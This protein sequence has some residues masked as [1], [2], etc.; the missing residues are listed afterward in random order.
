MHSDYPRLFHSTK[1]EANEFILFLVSE[2]LRISSICGKFRKK[3]F[4]AQIAGFP[5]TRVGE[6]GWDRVFDAHGERR[7]DPDTDLL[8]QATTSVAAGRTVWSGAP[9]IL[10]SERKRE[11]SRVPARVYRPSVVSHKKERAVPAILFDKIFHLF[12]QFLFF[13]IF[14]SIV[15]SSFHVIHNLQKTK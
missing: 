14:W 2:I 15:A 9:R 3:V 1:K 4:D 10:C 6:W 7:V 8:L 5:A 13:V 11:S 12:L